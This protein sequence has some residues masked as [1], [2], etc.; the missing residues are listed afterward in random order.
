MSDGVQLVRERKCVNIAHSL[1]T[2][3]LQVTEKAYLPLAKAFTTTLGLASAEEQTC[4][5]FIRRDRGAKKGFKKTLRSSSLSVCRR[6]RIPAPQTALHKAASREQA[7]QS[8]TKAMH[9]SS[10]KH[11]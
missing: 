11:I 8:K 1:D 2:L 7:A 9:C 6:C 3:H 10:E 5:L 4:E